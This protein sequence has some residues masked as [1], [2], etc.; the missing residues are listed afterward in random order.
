MTARVATD[1]R[2]WEHVIDERD[3]ERGILCRHCL[4]NRSAQLFYRPSK[5]N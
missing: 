3:V 2:V 5:G 4:H 1:V